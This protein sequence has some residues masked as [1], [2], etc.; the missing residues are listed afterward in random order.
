MP[1]V[2]V[3]RVRIPDPEGEEIQIVVPVEVGPAAS[4]GARPA[5]DFDLPG[6]L[7]E[8]NRGDRAA[9]RTVKPVAFRQRCRILANPLGGDHQVPARFKHFGLEIDRLVQRCGGGAESAHPQQGRP[10]GP[11]GRGAFRRFP[12]HHLEIGSR[13]RIVAKP[14]LSYS[15]PVMLARILTVERNLAGEV[16]VGQPQT[17]VPALD[18]GEARVLVATVVF[19]IERDRV[20]EALY[21]AVVVPPV[22]HPHPRCR[23]C[24]SA[25]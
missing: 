19:R 18:I 10:Q 17:R 4:P 6:D 25:S 12:K 2:A 23:K 13:H 11:E 14:Q 24:S 1:L 22:H 8:T 9:I 3:E 15:P 20:P 16:V 21:S 7:V 5:L